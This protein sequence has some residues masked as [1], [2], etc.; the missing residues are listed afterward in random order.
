MCGI[1]GQ[2]SLG[3][4]A[5]SGL[6][7]RMARCLA[8]RGP[9]GYGI[10]HDGIMA[11]GA[12][13]L[14]II[15][16]SAPAGPIFSEDR[17]VAVAFNGEIYNHKVLRT[18]LE[19][20]GHVFK[21][22]TDTEV[23]VHGYESWGLG[24]L[25]RLRGMFALAVWDAQNARLLLARDRTGEKPLYIAHVDNGLI[26]ASEA[27][28]LFEHPGLRRAV[29]TEA[30]PLYLTLGYVPPPMTMFAGIEKLA[31]G[32]YLL[33]CPEREVRARYWTP[34]MDTTAPH[35]PYPHAVRSVR[36]MLT[37]SVEM[38]LMSD[39]PIGAFLSGGLDST[40]V[41]AI[42]TRALGRP[43]E[44]FTVGF[45]LEA[46]SKADAKFNVDARHAAAAARDLNTHHHAIT[47]KQDES[48]AD[49][50]PYLVRQMDEPVS[51]HAIV[52]TAYV[53]ALARLSGVPVLLSGDASDELFLGY[54]HYRLDRVL[55][56]YMTLPHLLRAAADPLLSRL[57]ARFDHARKLAAKART[58]S[59]PTRR[60]LEWMRMLEIGPAAA[61]A[62]HLP[63]ESIYHT[64]DAVLHPLLTA[65][66][67]S[68]F[69]ERIA[70]TSLNL[71]VA[72]DSNMRVDKMSMLMSTEARAPFEDH[73]LVEMALR[74]PLAYKLRKGDVKR[75]LK[76][77]VADLVPREV[78]TRP[79]WGFAPPSSEW[80]RTLLRPLVERYLSREYVAAVG[81]F[82]PD[83]VAALVEAHVVR[84]EYHL[85]PVWTL[86][87]F[88]LWHALMIDQSLVLDG[89]LTPSDLLPQHALK[90]LS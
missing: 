52:Q 38:R 1:F 69:A 62:R 19:G 24:V 26:F 66:K 58:A 60:Y 64:V 65:P 82:D 9:D 30:L 34:V 85:W 43:V 88:H 55:E 57:P 81:L 16:L 45:E 3:G 54:P 78:L 53:S 20:L 61:L 90:S 86:L 21:T 37:E 42:M 87:V 35:V 23:I 72:E 32:E 17:Q 74:L 50:F 27:K 28:A 79:K 70:F 80:L 10:H 71:W 15:D 83:A 29:N 6:I 75:V 68:H 5:D 48:L 31:P 2:I 47:V 22:R 12:G 84:R 67:A 49:I 39:V 40:A 8:H 14:A 44:T 41:V 63:A 56:R 25:D 77:A 7:E 73:L 18:E 89:T 33:L 11:F 13:R 59:D 36:R 46:G 4:Q 76:D 51:Q